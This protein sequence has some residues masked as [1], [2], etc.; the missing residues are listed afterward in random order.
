MH[1]HE[2]NRLRQP[3]YA[4]EPAPGTYLLPFYMRKGKMRQE[5]GRILARIYQVRVFFGSKKYF[6]GIA[7][8]RDPHSK[9]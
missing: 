8:W 9:L 2:Q 6:L 5:M 3:N 1:Q 4:Q 7:A